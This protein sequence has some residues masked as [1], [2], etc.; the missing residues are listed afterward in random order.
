VAPLGGLENTYFFFHTEFLLCALDPSAKLLGSTN[1]K[2][3][4]AI[5][6]ALEIASE[7]ALTFGSEEDGDELLFLSWWWAEK[8][9]DLRSESSQ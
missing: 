5:S 2:Q 4:E 7:N 3:R 1:L 9:E 8:S 6:V